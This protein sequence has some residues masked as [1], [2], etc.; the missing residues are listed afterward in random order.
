MLF[1]SRL[2]FSSRG[3]LRNNSLIANA[4]NLM[5]SAGVTALFGFVFW[6]VVAR[7]YRSD[8]VGLATTLLSMSSLIS[9]FGLAGF[10]TVFIRF[11]PKA[12]RQSEQISNGLIISALASGLAAGLFCLLIPVLSSQLAFVRHNALYSASFIIF[13]I[14]TTWNTLTNAAL[15]AYRRTS[16][17]IIINILFSALKMCLPFAIHSG[18]PMTIFMFT[19]I[20]QVFNVSLSIGA[21]AKYYNYRPSLRLDIGILKE[22]RRYGFVMYIGGILNLLPDS[23]LPLIVIN[24]LGTTAAAYFYI[25]I[26][27]ANL[28]Y[29]VA[30]STA[31]SL[32]AE[33]ANDEAHIIEHLRTAV[34][35]AYGLLLPIIIVLAIAAPLFL[36]LFGSDY[37]SGATGTLRIMCCGGILVLAGALINSLFKQ[38]KL[39]TAMLVTTASN[40]IATIFFSLLLVQPLGLAGI[41]WGFVLG[42]IVSLTIG[43]IFIFKT[44]T[45]HIRKGV[46]EL[47]EGSR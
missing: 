1:G 41:G 47:I 2:R 36:R 31:Q 35:F 21:L 23:S 44:Y 45:V 3:I 19:G 16:L 18:G 15:I 4:L 34:K 24:T 6:T 27:I 29:T 30:F 8:V 38:Y 20:A 5:V 39:L 28:L 32:L 42:G 12:E 40:S 25:V 9:L 22:I 10:D 7:S 17:V 46:A 33:A 13:T 11:L 26:T 43:C 14:F 37:S